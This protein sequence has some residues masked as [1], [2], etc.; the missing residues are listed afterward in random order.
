MGK[1]RLMQVNKTVDFNFE[2]I[3]VQCIYGIRKILIRT[4]KIDGGLEENEKSFHLCKQN[5]KKI[6]GLDK[7][8]VFFHNQ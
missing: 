2:S 8:Y 6:S 1:V 7:Q 4:I 5:S 3:R